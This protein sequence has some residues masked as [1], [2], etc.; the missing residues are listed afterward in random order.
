MV[1]KLINIFKFIFFSDINED[2]NMYES[3]CKQIFQ[4][5]CQIIR[6]KYILRK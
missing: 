1:K 4:L 6:Q 5:I 3:I 2:K